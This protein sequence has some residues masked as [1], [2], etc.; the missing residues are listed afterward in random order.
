M[1]R[2]L[3][4][5]ERARELILERV[6]RLGG[7]RVP[8]A[9]ARGR[10][11]AEPV[12]A[13]EAVP[14]FDNSAMDGF[15]V[16]AADTSDASADNP[17]RLSVVDESRAGH[18]ATRS[19]E[20]GEAIAISTGAVIPDRA[21][22]VVRIEDTSRDGEVVVVLAGVEPGRNVRRAGEDMAA[23]ARVLEPPVRLRA[24]ELGAL[25][26]VGVEDPLCAIRPRLSVLLTGDELVAPGRPLGPGQIRDSNAYAVP[27]LAADG[28]AE[29]GAPAIAGDSL[30]ATIAAIERADA[31]ADVVVVCGGVSVGEHDHVRPALERLG[32]EQVFWGVALRPGKPT[33]F[34]LLADGTL[35]FGLPGNPVSAMVTF[36]LFVRPALLAMQGADPGFGRVRA[37]L[38]EAYEKV[39]GR[40]EAIR[41]RLALEDAGW[42]ATPTG[43]QGSHVLTSMLGADGLAF[44]PT[45]RE[46]LE[47]GESIE[48][49]PLR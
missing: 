17:G 5:I 27:P 8:L 48:V 34:G 43:P 4:T 9:E 24:A 18:P 45:E 35:A 29:V 22:A 2:E 36:L 15:A 46:R 33:W 47:A 44:A 30:P 25:A 38:G 13:A 23:G 6:P 37:R 41:V 21:D 12:D 31:D 40:A 49:E 26:T 10:F 39:H 11:L 32:A 7:E 16:R 14:R 28:G 1:T 42:V 19:L 20:A 3:I